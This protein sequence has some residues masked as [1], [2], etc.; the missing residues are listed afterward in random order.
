MGIDPDFYY[1]DCTSRFNNDVQ[2]ID[3]LIITFGVNQ[4]STVETKDF[5]S[6]TEQHGISENKD[7]FNFAYDIFNYIRMFREGGRFGLFK[8]RQAE[9]EGPVV[10]LLPE[11][12]SESDVELLTEGMFIYRGVSE[13]EF[14]C[15]KF[16][17]SWSTSFQV[18]KRF[19]VDT[20]SDMQRGIVAR[21]ALDKSKVIY[22]SKLDPEL[23][24]I[25]A[26]RSIVSAVRVME[27]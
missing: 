8:N 18:A 26:S 7:I 3:S 2:S 22:H 12:V 24:V 6:F 11:D 20:Y 17:Q 9:W 5:I 23:E 4:P 25:M 13:A 27:F 21:T 16:G 14:N 15:R 1:A 10:T 19:A